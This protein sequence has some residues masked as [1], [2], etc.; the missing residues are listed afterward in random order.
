MHSP[1]TI[2]EESGENTIEGYVNGVDAR[3]A[4]AIT[5]MENAANSSISAFQA[6]MNTTTLYTAGQ[7]AIQGAIN[8]INSMVPSLVAAATSAGQ[9]ASQA[10]KD[11]QDIHSPSKVFEY[12]GQMDMMGAIQGIEKNQEKANA[13]FEAAGLE[14]AA[15]YQDAVNTQAGYARLYADQNQAVYADIPG[16]MSQAVQSVNA[17]TDSRGGV[18]INYSPVYNLSGVSNSNDVRSTLNEFDATIRSD[19]KEFIIETVA[20]HAA[21]MDRRVIR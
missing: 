11:A 17:L 15:A 12:F 21:D 16:V 2:T 19:L 14:N 18:V 10:Y 13:A 6:Q 9:Q 20:D 5:A 4:D 7:N 1:S 8:G 3:T